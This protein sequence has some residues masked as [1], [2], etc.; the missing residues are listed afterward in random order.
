MIASAYPSIDEDG[1]SSPFV[2]TA[3]ADERHGP[4]PTY[5]GYLEVK[6]DALRLLEGSFRE[7]LCRSFQGP[8]SI[9][10]GYIFI[11]EQETSG[12]ESWDDGI[13]WTHIDREGDFW[14]SR[15]TTSGDGLLKKTI[16]IPALGRFH[17]VVSYYNPWDT[18]NGKLKVPSEDANLGN[19]TLRTDLASQFTMPPSS[20]K[21]SR[22]LRGILKVNPSLSNSV[23]Q[24]SLQCADLFAYWASSTHAERPPPLSVLCG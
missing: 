14:I 13:S 9:R 21:Q 2:S 4:V 23:N 7:L 5:I 16:S 24:Y 3:S 18:L 6:E 10:S 20:T 22:L 12:I 19:M 15:E 17:H 1:G 8:S 11:W